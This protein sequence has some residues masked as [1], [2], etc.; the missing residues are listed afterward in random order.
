MAMPFRNGINPYWKH[1]Q[2]QARPIVRHKYKGLSFMDILMKYRYLVIIPVVL[3]LSFLWGK[4]NNLLAWLAN[5]RREKTSRALHD[6]RVERVQNRIRAR[7]P[8]KDGLICTAR[9]PMWSISMRPV[10]YKTQHRYAVD[11]SDLRDVVAIDKE[12]MLA[13]VEPGVNMAVLSSALL[14]HGLCVPVLPEYEDLTVGGLVIGYGIEGSS[15][16]YGLFADTLESAD[17]VLADG[18]LAHCTR[19]NEYSDLFHALPWSYGALGMLVGVEIR[20]IPAKPYMRVTYVPIRGT[21]QE[22]ADAYHQLL[23][24]EDRP[25]AEYVEGLIFNSTTGVVTIADYASEQEARASGAI[26]TMGL[27]YKRWFHHYAHDI[28]K[29]QAARNGAPYTEYVPTRDYF[30]RHTRSLYWMADLVSVCP[31]RSP[32]VV[33]FSRFAPAVSSYPNPSLART[34]NS[35]TR[36]SPTYIVH[37]IPRKNNIPSSYLWVTT[38]YSVTFSVGSCHLV[39]LSSSC[40]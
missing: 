6:R 10:E 3:P 19:D 18:T 15:H 13:Y 28:V 25:W 20:L 21:V 30:L 34:H 35:L 31:V 33:Q 36:P 2:P 8:E 37:L 7:N 17:V 4:I 11:L 29:E 16:I 24:P 23:V 5:L 26:N 39:Y 22:M 40:P 1:E 14:P 27:W 12:R 9:R 32:R 38:G